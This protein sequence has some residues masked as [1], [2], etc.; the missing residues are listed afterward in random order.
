MGDTKL[1]A[2]TM[3]WTTP[4]PFLVLNECVSK[5]CTNFEFCEGKNHRH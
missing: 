2:S 3:K 5:L 4:D 1:G